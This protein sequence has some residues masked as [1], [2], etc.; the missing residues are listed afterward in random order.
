[1]RPLKSKR[2]ENRMSI[3]IDGLGLDGLG[4]LW[5]VLESSP[6]CVKILDLNGRL[7]SI[8]DAGRVFLGLASA[9]YLVGRAWIDVL[10]KDSQPR[11]LEAL[12][13]ARHGQTVR[14]STA[15][16]TPFGLRHCD[17]TA[18]PLRDLAGAVV[19]ILAVTRDVTDLVVAR[20]DAEVRETSLARKAAA[21]RAAGLVAKLGAWE[22]D[23][24]QDAIFW[25]EELWS[26]MGQAPR[27]IKTDEA[28]GFFALG[29]LS[30]IRATF[31]TCRQTGEPFTFETQVRRMDGS[32]IWVRVFGEADKARSVLRGAVQ[33]ITDR[34]RA[35]SQ[36]IA[37]RDAAEAATQAKSAF[38]A[39]MSHE[40][41]TPL[42]GIIGMAQVVEREP[43]SRE[44]KARLGVIRQS[45]DILMSLLND[46]LDLSKIEAGMLQIDERDFDLTTV[47]QA[48]CAQ[49]AFQAAQ[50]D[51]SLELQVDPS[52]AGRWRGDDMRLRQIIS[53]L[54]SNAVKFTTVGGVRVTAE[55]RGEA[56]A[57]RVADTGA[58][59]EPDSVTRL[60]Q[61]FT[62]GDSSTSRRFG[63]TGL[64]LAISR[65]LAHLMGGS[66]E[67]A[68]APGQ[69]SSFLLK[70]PLARAAC[71]SETTQS[72]DE[73]APD[74]GLRILAAEDNE[75]NQ[76]ILR[77]M[78]SPLGADLTLVDN[79][80]AV[81]KVFAQSPF[82]L[83]LMDIQMPGQN[84][85]EATRAI[86]CLKQRQGRSPTPILAL[87]ANVMAHQV[88]EYLAA[89]MD[90]VVEKPIDIAKLFRAIGQALSVGDE[91]GA[92]MG[93]ASLDGPE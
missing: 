40:I 51:L 39:N 54:V 82:H 21:L 8:N 48:T 18:T 55:N 49:F 20:I 38:L 56:L 4:N 73:Q 75:T 64:G 89:G 26:L 45:G 30:M 24:A 46:I 7:R 16:H 10:P 85:V 91:R 83:I 6:D 59:M 88:Q 32:E 29:D 14:L 66:L 93:L 3:D 50:K 74:P 61:N 37:A 23:Y 28:F 27:D 36:L 15:C 68:T 13:Q 92:P 35:E 12:L 84:G 34:R 62:Q 72:Q 57:V 86:R 47:L 87:S 58:G 42:H 78:L 44:Q 53:N 70:L 63:G 22:I 52:A 80:E 31:A 33:D 41:R 25:S 67:A 60:F 76:L 69:G 9:D 17:L 71:G 77:S 5:A 79:G 1:M 11:A 19:A 43:L 65:H 90:G 81:V 2:H